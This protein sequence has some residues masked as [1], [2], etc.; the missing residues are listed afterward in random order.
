MTSS[1]H[2][3][4]HLAETGST[5]AD[6][7]RFAAAG[8]T[9]PLWVTADHQTAGRGRAGRSWVSDP[10]NLQASLA[11]SCDA[12]L[13]NAGQL[14]LLAGIALVDAIRAI[15]P[16]AER[17]PLRLKWPNDVLIGSA[18]AGGIL[19]ETTTARGEPGFKPGFLAVIGFGVN[20][21]TCPG[22]LGRATSSL[23][24][25]GISVTRDDLLAAL[26]DQCDV[27]IAHW[28]GGKNFAE[29]RQAWMERAGPIGEAIALQT[30]SGPLSATY[31]GLSDAGALLADTGGKI[32]TITYGDV[33]L[34]APTQQ[35][36]G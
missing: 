10:V 15:S 22:D 31:Q 20:V 9:L 6:A 25:S 26:A 36:G 11:F 3:I 23:G 7:M 17:S 4:V 18:K 13:Q 30:A 24:Q 2:R 19:V 8:E 28:D 12:P 21:A 27:W 34:I 14:S 1:R 5:N 29:L 33:T 35:S 32:E 16:L